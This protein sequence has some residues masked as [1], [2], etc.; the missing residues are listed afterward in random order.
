MLVDYLLA[1]VRPGEDLEKGA[2]WE[3]Q[4]VV[5]SFEDWVLVM[6]TTSLSQEHPVG[7]AS[8]LGAL[9]TKQSRQL[10]ESAPR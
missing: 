8:Q 2:G 5:N 1:A 7:L 9:D 6:L 3:L 4:F 10:P